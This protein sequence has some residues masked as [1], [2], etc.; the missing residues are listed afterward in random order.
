MERQGDATVPEV[1]VLPHG[2]VMECGMVHHGLPECLDVLLPTLQDV[3]MEGI[4]T[5][6]VDACEQLM[7]KQHVVVEGNH[8]VLRFF[9]VDLRGRR[10]HAHHA[11]L[12]EPRQV[13]VRVLRVPLVVNAGQRC[14]LWV[15]WPVGPGS[16]ADACNHGG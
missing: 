11:R 2:V 10:G 1:A 9:H 16:R 7:G 12:Q 8:A 3:P 14:D 15:N 13:A 4:W 6:S 5:M